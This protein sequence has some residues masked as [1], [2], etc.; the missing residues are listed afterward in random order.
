MCLELILYFIHYCISSYLPT[1][2]PFFTTFW[3]LKIKIDWI[4][5]KIVNCAARD[6]TN[7]FGVFPLR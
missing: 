6:V 5:G 4:V 3:R 7:E 2:W 1:I